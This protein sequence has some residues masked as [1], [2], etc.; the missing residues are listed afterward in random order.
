M[1][2]FENTE[3]LSVVSF[4]V[5]KCSWDTQR[6]IQAVEEERKLNLGAFDL[7]YF[8]ILSPHL[9]LRTSIASHHLH[10]F[11]CLSP[12]AKDWKFLVL[13]KEQEGSWRW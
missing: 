5:E 9:S 13:M 4:Q 12:F 2:A 7:L 10:F 1:C 8:S 3:E 11:V 6:K